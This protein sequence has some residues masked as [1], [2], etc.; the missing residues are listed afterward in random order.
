[1]VFGLPL[2]VEPR[3]WLLNITVMGTLL[4]LWLQ[5]RSLIK[6]ASNF[7]TEEHNFTVFLTRGRLGPK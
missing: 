1:M 6:L 7:T 3:L 2:F 5:C 4:K